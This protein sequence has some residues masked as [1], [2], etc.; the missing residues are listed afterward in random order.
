MPK[1]EV[2]SEENFS[3][4]QS[5]D[6]GNPSVNNYLKLEY[7]ALDDSHNNISKTLLLVEDNEVIAYISS[8]VTEI[9]IGYATELDYSSS[10]FPSIPA[11]E[12]QYMGVSKQYQRRE[13]GKDVL[14]YLLI[15]VY[16]MSLYV[17]CRYVFAWSVENSI[18]FYEAMGFENMDTE[19]KQA[20][21]MRFLIPS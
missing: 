19:F 21:L 11:C 5:F 1:F 10:T 17:G 20:H 8:R 14:S 13:Y 2:L 16:E 9:D 12:I 7:H 3:Y 4:L 15:K 18:P 6:C